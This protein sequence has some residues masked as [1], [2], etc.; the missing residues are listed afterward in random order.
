M[1][2]L[3]DNIKEYFARVAKGLNAADCKSVDHVSSGVRIPPLAPRILIMERIPRNI[4]LQ[5]ARTLASSGITKRA[6]Q[7]SFIG[8][9]VFPRVLKSKSDG[10]DYL[11]LGVDIT[12]KRTKIIPVGCIMGSEVQVIPPFSSDD[13]EIVCSLASDTEEFFVQNGLDC[14]I[15]ING[16]YQ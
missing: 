15:D 10:K 12:P 3:R 6:M 9:D 1:F 4:L 14:S 5:N 7:N 13:L 11:Y 8:G 16:I 2:L